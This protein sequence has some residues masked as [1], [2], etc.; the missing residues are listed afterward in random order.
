[1]GTLYWQLNDC[2]PGISWSSIDY[3]GKWKALHY[4]AKHAFENVLVSFERINDQLKVYIINDELNDIEEILQLKLLN[5]N[6]DV[7]WSSSKSV[8]VS[9][10]SSKLV[11]L[12][13]I[14]SKIIKDWNQVLLTASFGSASNNYYF[15]KPKDLNLVNADIEFDV[16]K[17]DNGY[18]INLSSNFFQKDVVLSSTSKGKFSDNYFDIIPQQTKQI[19]FKTKSNNI[20]NLSFNRLNKVFSTQSFK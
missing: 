16:I 9:P 7:L 4:A 2:W 20:G 8:K 6:G 19:F 1:M 10:S 18:L 13:A 14:D 3:L 5:F 12:F 15:V 17:I 11:D